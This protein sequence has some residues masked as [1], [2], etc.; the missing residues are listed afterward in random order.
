[1]NTKHYYIQIQHS[2]KSVNNLQKEIDK[3]GRKYC[4]WV[5]RNFETFI[6]ELKKEHEEAIK[7]F[8]RCKKE[9]FSYDFHSPG[10]PMYYIRL[11][12]SLTLTA[13]EVA[14]YQ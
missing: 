1:M 3:I 6:S 4:R 10:V 9:N 11:S 12:E 7:A 14:H 13:T 8:P 2:T 5:V